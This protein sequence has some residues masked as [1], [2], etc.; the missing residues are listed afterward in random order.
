MWRKKKKKKKN[1]TFILGNGTFYNPD[2]HLLHVVCLSRRY[3]VFFFI[4]AKG[5]GRQRD[6]WVEDGGKTE[7]WDR[8]RKQ[9][10]R[11]KAVD[12]KGGQASLGVSAGSM[13]S[14]T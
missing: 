2:P 12:I 9:W 6:G 3:H 5:I 4:S 11:T 7:S 14:D 1:S 13:Y 10:T 8:E